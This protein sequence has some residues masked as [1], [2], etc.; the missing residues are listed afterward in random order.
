MEGKCM[1]EQ[2]LGGK[3]FR[4]LEVHLSYIVWI[5]FMCG[6]LFDCRLQRQGVATQKCGFW[7]ICHITFYVRKPLLFTNI[8][9]L[10]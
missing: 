5:D 2:N 7:Q 1:K 10:K 4:S 8:E 3:I 6:N 9:C